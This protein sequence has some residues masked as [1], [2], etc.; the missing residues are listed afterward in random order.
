[1]TNEK[2]CCDQWY[3]DIKPCGRKA[4]YLVSTKDGKEKRYLCELHDKLYR[5]VVAAKQLNAEILSE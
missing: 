1:M 5:Q 2:L 3:P 4:K